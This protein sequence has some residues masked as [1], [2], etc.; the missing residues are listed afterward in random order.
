MRRTGHVLLALPWLLMGAACAAWMVL[1][2]LLSAREGSGLPAA[3]LW[4]IVA[5]AGHAF[6]FGTLALLLAAVHLR[7][8][9]RGAPGAPGRSSTWPE[10]TR[11]KIAGLLVAVGAYGLVDEWH[12]S[13]VPGRGPSAL[14]VLTDLVGAG[15]VLWIIAYLG[16]ADA[17]GNGLRARLLACIAAC[18]GAAA[19][20]T[21]LPAW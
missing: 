8:D 9:T 10:L 14:D 20:S 18:V 12:Q 2:W 4:P 1:I 16:R 11:G 15:C 13:L 3:G 21:A 19:V 7:S 6:L 17:C 5:N